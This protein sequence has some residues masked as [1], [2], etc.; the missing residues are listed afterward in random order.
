MNMQQIKDEYAKEQK[1]E[2]WDSL[3]NDCFYFV[4][5]LTDVIDEIAKRYAEA[6]C[7]ATLEKAAENATVDLPSHRHLHGSKNVYKP[8]ITDPSNIVL[9]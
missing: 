8:S 4:A 6:C 5:E 1:Y 2:D 9:L 3:I 7:K